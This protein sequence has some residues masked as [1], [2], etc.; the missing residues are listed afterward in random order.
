M[1]KDSVINW[2]SEARLRCVRVF[3]HS[4]RSRQSNKLGKKAYYSWIAI[5]LL[6]MAEL[7]AWL[8]L[9]DNQGH[10]ISLVVASSFIVAII[11]L[12]ALGLWFHVVFRV[13][14]TMTKLLANAIAPS[15]LGVFYLFVFVIHIGWTSNAVN[16]IFTDP[17]NGEN[18]WMSFLISI[19]GIFTLIL[20]FP[21]G[22][23]FKNREQ[24]TVFVSG[25]SN[26]SVPYGGNYSKLNLRPFVRVLQHIP[27]DDGSCEILVLLSNTEHD[28]QSVLTFLGDTTDISAMKLEDQLRL[29]IKQVA[30]REF[31][32]KK[33][34]ND[35]TIN[36]T[37]PCDYND[38][39]RC[40]DTLASIIEDKDDANHHMVF[41]LTPGTVTVSSL[42]TLLAIDGDR[43]L[44]YYNQ[45]KDL[46]DEDRLQIVDKTKMP[47]HNLLSQA[48][49]KMDKKD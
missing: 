35:L 11:L 28:V 26:I 44:I 29:L 45:D 1:K 30:R 41:N 32:S 22:R 31:P 20:F 24:T 46:S 14:S 23:K 21:E 9:R 43:E 12:M 34:I 7:I 27:D 42:M 36:F 39:K 15:T 33:W 48:L 19:V 2:L 18:A 17:V 40:Y 3:P 49:E 13:K 6:L 38:F 5:V 47:L 4:L 25:L 37:A 16:S 10:Q 8:A